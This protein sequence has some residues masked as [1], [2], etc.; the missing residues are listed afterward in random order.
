MNSPCLPHSISQLS[1][2]TNTSIFVMVETAH[3][4]RKWAGRNTLRDNF[5]RGTLKVSQGDEELTTEESEKHIS[6]FAFK[7][8][9]ELSTA[10]TST[11]GSNRDGFFSQPNVAASSQRPHDQPQQ[12]QQ[13]SSSQ[14]AHNVA[15]G[16]SDA[17]SSS[18]SKLVSPTSSSLEEGTVVGIQAFTLPS[19]S[20]SSETPSS[21]TQSLSNFISPNGEN[22]GRGNNG[23]SSNGA[24]N[25]V[26]Q[27]SQ[28]QSLQS[29]SSGQPAGSSSSHN[30]SQDNSYKQSPRKDLNSDFLDDAG[31]AKRED[32]GNSPSSSAPAPALQPAPLLASVSEQIRYM[33]SQL[34]MTPDQITNVLGLPLT[35]VQNQVILLNSVNR[36]SSKTPAAIPSNNDASGEFLSSNQVGSAD[37]AAFWTV[38]AYPICLRCVLIQ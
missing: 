25:N 15:T 21:S 6:S 9:K 19:E 5:L 2:L 38:L 32:S 23:G 30:D 36:T 34:K 37:W 27:E 26:N 17:A 28:Q 24:R 11:N 31:P 33:S 14:N 18:S 20:T 22:N 12:G 10:T 3:G 29:S 4:G 35:Y 16:N 1:S 8:T 13:R 7:P